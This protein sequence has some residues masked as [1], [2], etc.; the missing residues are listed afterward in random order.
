MAGQTI[1][2]QLLVTNTGDTTLT[3]IEVKDVLDPGGVLLDITLDSLPPGVTNS[4]QIAYTIP[5]PPPAGF[6]NNILTANAPLSSVAAESNVFIDINDSVPGISISKSADHITAPP[7][8]IV[9]Y[10]LVVSNTGTTDLGSVVVSDP[11][12]G[13]S[14]TIDLPAGESTTQLVL[15]QVPFGTAA[16]TLITNTATA[17]ANG[18]TSQSSWTVTVSAE[19]EILLEKDADV[20]TAVPGDIVQYTFTITNIGNLP[21][22]GIVLTDSDIGVSIPIGSLDVGMSVQP[23]ADFMIPFGT[24]AGTFTNNASVTSDQG[25]EGFGSGVVM[26]SPS[27]SLTFMK[28]A[29]ETLASP[30]DSISYTFNFFNSGNITLTNVFLTDPTLGIAQSIETLLPGM[31]FGLE[32]LDE[33]TIPAGSLPGTEFTNTA[34]VT[35]D[36]LAPIQSSA[37]V[38]VQA[39]PSISLDKSVL[40]TSASIGDTVI[41]TFVIT[42]NGN[43]PLTGIMLTD[44]TLGISLNIPDLDVGA[45]NTQMID[46]VVPMDALVTII[47]TAT[48]TGDASGTTVQAQAMATLTVNRPII[49]FTKT[50]DHSS[51]NPGD[52]VTF[53]IT[54]NYFGTEPN[55][56]VQLDDELLDVHVGFF[57]N[58][59]GFA[60][61]TSTFVIPALP[62]GTVI[63]NTATLT[64]NGVM[65][66]VSATVTVNS[67]PAIS[68]LKTANTASAAPGDTITY[69]ITVQ[70]TGNVVLP[71]VSVMDP[72]LGISTPPAPLAIGGSQVVMGSFTIPLGT[73]AGTIITNTAT[74]SSSLT[75][76]T[77]SSASVSV[78]SAPVLAITKTA[79]RSS[80]AP[81][82]TIFYTITVTNSSVSTI[83]GIQLTD[84]VLG[85]SVAIGTLGPGDSVNVPASFTVPAGTPAGTIITNTATVRSPTTL[86]AS[87]S[88]SVTVAVGTSLSITKSATPGSTSA[89]GI[90]IYTITVTNTGNTV[91][92]NTTVSD[93]TLSL[94]IP[95]GQLQPGQSRSQ[96]IPFQ[97]PFTLAPG[98]VFTNTA[99]ATSDQTSPVQ[100]SAEVFVLPP[101]QATVT[102]SPFP[103]FGLSGGE[104]TVTVTV[105]NPSSVTL[106][107]LVLVND[108]LGIN[109]TVPSLAPG[110]SFS[111]VR[112]VLIP[113]GTPAGTE[114][115]SL[116]ILNTDQTPT[117]AAQ[118]LVIVQPAPVLALSKTVRAPEAVP[119]EKVRFKIQAVNI[120]NTVLTGVL[121]DPL[122]QLAIGP[123]TLSPQNRFT[124][125]VPF[126]IPPETLNGATI[127]NTAFFEG[128]GVAQQ[129]SA[130]VKVLRV[131]D[132]SK[133][134]NKKE[135]FLGDTIRF[136]ILV[137][138]SSIFNAVNS[139]L[140]D[141]LAPS[142]A[143]VPGSVTVNDVVQPDSSL[144]SGVKLGTIGPGQRVV[145]R[146][147]VKNLSIPR[148]TGSS[149]TQSADPQS[150]VLLNQAV[151]TFHVLS[152]SG[153]N[154]TVQA[155]SNISRVIVTE[156]E[157]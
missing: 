7:G 46:F 14:A 66:E 19:A 122:L 135:S 69:T 22:T 145:V 131:L 108:F 80:A 92:T 88:V 53:M 146:F 60:S 39:A 10:S 62:G 97:L 134:S 58:P 143:L 75:S 57:L 101:P 147:T 33:F 29:S 56:F 106:T 3:Q 8:E 121:T 111:I 21:L 84:A 54:I 148:S 128:S 59:G 139:V 43:V 41:Y 157:E 129:A 153:R 87:D 55:F 109:I 91:L 17:T 119:G 11:T 86:P 26:I 24:P 152:P 32:F 52:T 82:E 71:D 27:A 13:F 1:Y 141:V 65:E 51:A 72:L 74:A 123:I 48:V 30:G 85:L 47:N 100:A 76:P 142:V 125:S 20:S 77:Q 63:T 23:T 99:T 12:L 16:G 98:S 6:L 112:T 96:S 45:S 73:P 4:Q 155:L 31:D 107:N 94:S 138:N 35:T 114:L 118:V 93:P 81:E 137:E 102:V 127:T 61:D 154:V 37:T 144:R 140:Q 50:V 95:V 70:N 83:N 133:K 117:T 130:S 136:T 113:A 18:V 79:D 64:G 42:N 38:T 105:T 151:V 34:T 90:V 2:F 9:E 150:G 40:P 15:F 124:V 78:L 126:V 149:L 49:D 89:G 104:V 132:V 25:A 68:I 44:P 115:S 110:G 28:T 5:D 103:A 67:V 36:Q 116:A 156:E 120:G